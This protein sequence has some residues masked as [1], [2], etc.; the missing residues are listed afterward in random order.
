MPHAWQEIGV[1]Q[2]PA[3]IVSCYMLVNNSL[4]HSKDIAKEPHPSLPGCD[5]IYSMVRILN[6]KFKP[7]EK[8]NSQPST[9]E[10]GG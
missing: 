10:N 3:I 5:H 8:S 9:L 2:I 6:V 1:K 4:V 7:R